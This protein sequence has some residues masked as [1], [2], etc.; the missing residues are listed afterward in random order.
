MSVTFYTAASRIYCTSRTTF[1]NTTRTISCITICKMILQFCAKLVQLSVFDIIVLL[2]TYSD[3]TTESSCFTCDIACTSS[4]LRA[5]CFL[6]VNLTTVPRL[7]TAHLFTEINDTQFQ[8]VTIKFCITIRAI[9][10][11]VD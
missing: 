4:E 11:C 8:T 9:L 6:P 5:L 2:L 1:C 10:I 7:H 3:S